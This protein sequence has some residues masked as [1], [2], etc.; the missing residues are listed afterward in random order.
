MG[1]TIYKEEQTQVLARYQVG[2]PDHPSL[3]LVERR[4]SERGKWNRKG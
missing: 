2:E 1:S 4:G 3:P